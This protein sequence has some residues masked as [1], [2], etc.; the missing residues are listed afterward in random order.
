MNSMSYESGRYF[1]EQV[2]DSQ[3]SNNFQAALDEGASLGWTLV[4]FSAR[5]NGSFDQFDLVWD[6]GEWDD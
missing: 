1:H 4:T 2:D 3:L 5:N 6:K